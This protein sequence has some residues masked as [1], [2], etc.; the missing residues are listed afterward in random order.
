MKGSK[1]KI[2]SQ[3]VMINNQFLKNKKDEQLEHMHVE[4]LAALDRLSEEAILRELEARFKQN[5][6]H[7]F[8]GDILLVLNPNEHQNIYNDKVIFYVIFNVIANNNF[9]S[10]L[11]INV[12][13]DLVML[14]IFTPWPTVPTKMPFTT[15][16]NNAYFYQEKVV[17]EKPQISCILSII[18][19]I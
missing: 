7:T 2:K 3:E 16:S 4:D 15:N 10:I 18:C 12:N 14:L 1:I 13:Q 17:Q 6:F 5:H 19:C 8:I 11:N 9:S